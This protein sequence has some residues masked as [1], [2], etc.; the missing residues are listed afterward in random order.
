MQSGSRIIGRGEIIKS[1]VN[2][3]NILILLAITGCGH[4]DK[5][6]REDKILQGT[7]LFV[8]G[9]DWLQT[10]EIVDDPHYWETNP[11]IGEDPTTR[12][13]DRYFIMSAGLGT[14][15]THILPQEYRKYWLMF[16]IGTSSAMVMHNY[17][18]GIR[19]KL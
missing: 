4:F 8:Q 18:I 16:R 14:L 3:L 1:A 6:T 17:H 2:I 19:I 11:H 10:R 5:W 7:Q 12:D 13:V 15:V 9:I